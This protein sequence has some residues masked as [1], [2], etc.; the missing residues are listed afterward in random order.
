MTAM[1]SSSSQRVRLPV[2]MEIHPLHALVKGYVHGCVG[3]TCVQG[4]CVFMYMA[5]QCSH[6]Q[7]V[8]TAVVH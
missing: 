7:G 1:A 3:H 6:V 5:V 8:Q 4:A 2:S